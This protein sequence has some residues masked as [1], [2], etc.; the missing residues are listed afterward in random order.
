MSKIALIYLNLPALHHCLTSVMIINFQYCMLILPL[1]NLLEKKKTSSL[2][3]YI[4][5][6]IC[7][8]AR[9]PTTRLFPHHLLILGMPAWSPFTASSVIKEN[10]LL[11]LIRIC[12]EMILRFRAVL[13]LIIFPL[14]VVHGSTFPSFYL[15]I[16]CVHASRH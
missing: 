11:S 1:A 15:F 9:H 6:L 5:H 10:P 8:C 7:Y 13:E 12:C 16:Q 4:V 14:E 2:I 3:L